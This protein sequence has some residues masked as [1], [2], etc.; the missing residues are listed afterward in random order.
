MSAMNRLPLSV[1][2]NM[3]MLAVVLLLLPLQADLVFSASLEQPSPT[4]EHPQCELSPLFNLTVF[5]RHT[6]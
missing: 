6:T 4:P 1:T 2:S 3:E 5:H